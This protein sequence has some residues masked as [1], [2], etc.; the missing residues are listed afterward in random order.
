ME[1]A[2]AFKNTI[3]RFA[4]SL[5]STSTFTSEAQTTR[6]AVSVKDEVETLSLSSLKDRPVR[7]AARSS[8][9]TGIKNESEDGSPKKKRRVL[10]R[11]YADPET[12]AHLNLV[13]DHLALSLDGDA[14][15]PHLI[16]E[17][18]SHIFFFRIVMFC[19]IKLDLFLFRVYISCHF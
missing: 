1:P 2:Q 16:F 15:L 13:P 9:R 3:S 12:Y 4:F 5:P 14:I 6:G 18:L 17:A 11:G 8:V 10:K 19:G 7:P